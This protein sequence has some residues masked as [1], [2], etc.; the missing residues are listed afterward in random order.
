MDS[1]TEKI[2]VAILNNPKYAIIDFIDIIK[3]IRSI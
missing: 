2:A 3:N 1:T